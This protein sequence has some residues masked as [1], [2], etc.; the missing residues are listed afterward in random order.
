[1]RSA[2]AHALL[3]AHDPALPAL[4]DLLDAAALTERLGVPVSRGYLRYKPGTSAVTLL[5]VGGRPAIAQAWAPGSGDKRAKAL[6]YAAAED[7]LL[8]APEDGLLVLDA[9]ADR[10]I[11]SLRLLVRS[12]RVGPWLTS[13]GH[14]VAPDATPKTL[15]YKPARRWVGRI[16][17]ARTGE[18]A[19]LRAYAGDGYGTALAAH[20][21]IDPDRCPSVRLPRVLGT[22][23][24]GL[25]ALEHLPGRVLDTSLSAAAL[26]RLGASLGELHS[27]RV[28]DV[29]G[30]DHPADAYGLSATAPVLGEV[31]AE[32][33]RV[34][35]A[36]RA[37]LRPGQGS[38]IHGDFSLDQVVA[39]G[40]HLGIIDLDRVR[41][42]HPLDD[43]A[44]LLAAA[45][46]TALLTGGAA[47][48]ATLMDR[49]RTPVVAG[50]ASVWDG[51]P[52]EDLGPRTALELLSRAGEPFRAGAADWPTV[53]RELITLAGSLVPGRVAA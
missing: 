30:A 26:R 22:H 42:G 27:S 12:G 20:G 28:A 25:I 13:A 39:D 37:A 33:R 35:E 34:E 31:V 51:A 36:A 53:T 11:P 49:M 23:R 8:D 2:E 17:L 29:V 4:A 10:R 46:V 43:I 9:L 47:G 14:P 7:V 48:A 24:R 32:A 41:L 6:K 1:M 50:H 19:V 16:P 44:S 45:A 52:S 3:A 5:D 15:A 21:L 18:S 38:V 40:H